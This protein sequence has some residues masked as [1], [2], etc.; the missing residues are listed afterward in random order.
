M[1]TST[2][3][4]S[5]EK[6]RSICSEFAVYG[7]FLL[8]VPFGTGHIN[9]TF[10]VTYDQGGVRLHYILQRI[11]HVVFPHPDQVMENIDRVTTH[12][13]NKIRSRGEETRKRTIRLLRTATDQPFVR[14]GNDDFW[15]MYI[16]VENA[17]SYDVFAT[18]EQAYRTA[19]AF[20]EFQCDLVDLPGGRLHETI[21]DFHN[22]P[23]RIDALL[24]AIAE[25]KV[26]RVA[27]VEREIEFVLNRRDEA[28]RL[29]QLHAA[30]A[31][32]ERITHNDTKANNIL[33]DDVSGEGVCVIDLD[34]VMPGLALYDFGD[35]VRSG[36]SSAEE[37][38]VN[39]DL[40][41]M[42]FDL[43][44][45][46]LKGFLSSADGFLTEVERECLPFSGKLIT[47][48]T[49]IRFLTDH[50]NGDVYFK[51]HRANHNLERC[52]NQFKLVE[53]IERQLN[54]MNSLLR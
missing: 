29:L 26:G 52:R 35:M 41:E 44:E 37:D 34:T 6:I 19:R 11:N 15:R 36:T 32:P 39:L 16:F 21:K 50:I 23:K 42:R 47:L 20:G 14:D 49:G 53:S 31:I 24:S 54:Q 18:P 22:T 12:L 25:N 46:L 28:E 3:Q 5:Q 1:S 45:A 10:Q 17:R 2:S 40:V 43:F 33:I 48:E 30:G 13:L 7:D 27:G 51:T 4:F 38:E 9:D 8:A